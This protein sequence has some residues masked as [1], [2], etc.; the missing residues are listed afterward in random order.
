[1]TFLYDVGP[2]KSLDD[3]NWNRPQTYSVTLI[4]H[5]PGN[6]TTSEVLGE[7]VPT[8]PDNVGPRSTPNYGALADAAVTSLPGGIK[9]FAGQRDDPFYVDLGPVFDLAVLPEPR[10]LAARERAL[11]GTAARSCRRRA[12][13]DL[14]DQPG[15]P[16]G[17][18][19]DGGAGEPNFQSQL[20]RP[21][22]SRLVAAEHVD[23]SDRSRRQGGPARR[24]RRRPRR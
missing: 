17:D 19:A 4:K 23:C 9:V 3:P 18:S 21:E 14:R 11:R 12:H 6:S 20:H 16:G 22:E 5:G 15:R 24:P 7:N 10:G 8:P 13:A 1:N 2:I